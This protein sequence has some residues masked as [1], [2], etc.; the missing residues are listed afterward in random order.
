L[1]MRAGIHVEARGPIELKGRGAMQTYF[2][3]GRA[4]TS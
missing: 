2:L 3:L 1:A 4:K